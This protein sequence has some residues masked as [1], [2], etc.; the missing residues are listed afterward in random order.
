M[1]LAAI[2]AEFP[3]P[4][5][6]VQH[7]DP[8]HR[9][10]IVPIMQR[11]THLAVEEATDGQTVRPGTVYIAPPNRHLLVS[12]GLRMLLVDTELVHFVRPSADLLFDSL[13]ASCKEGVLGVV[14]TGNG[15]DGAKGTVAIKKMGG[16]VISQDLEDAEFPGMPSAV[17][18][19]GSADYVLPLSKIPAKIMEL[20]GVLE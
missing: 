19:A 3:L 8:T 2:P 10:M 6:V 12:N 20:V 18:A 11:V 5:V 4:I 9:S 7:L 15:V 13:A 14:L 1:L 17:L 16:T